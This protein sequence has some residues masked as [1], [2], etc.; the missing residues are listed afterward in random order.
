[1]VHNGKK[2]VVDG[3]HRLA[4]AKRAGFDSVPAVERQ[5]PI[6]GYKTASDLLDG[7]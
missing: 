6:N 5:L 7:F 4:A 2:Y 3:H 1:M